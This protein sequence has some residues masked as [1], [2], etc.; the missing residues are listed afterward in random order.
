MDCNMPV[1][2]GFAATQAI[3]EFEKTHAVEG[4]K[5][6]RDIAEKEVGDGDTEKEKLTPPPQ[7][8]VPIV[9]LTAS[10]SKEC[11]AKCTDCGMDECLTKPLRVCISLFLFIFL[12]V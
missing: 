6:P 4:V 3:R 8:H 9:A 10:D 5:L 1:M 12:S 7:K 2:D 11:Q